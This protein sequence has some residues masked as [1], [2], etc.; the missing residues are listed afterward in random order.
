MAIKG[1]AARDYAYAVNADRRRATELQRAF[2]AAVYATLGPGRPMST[3]NVSSGNINSEMA[4]N[5]A[6]TTAR[7]RAEA[8]KV[9]NV[10]VSSIDRAKV[11]LTRGTEETSSSVDV[12]VA[13]TISAIRSG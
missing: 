6:D 2:G 12:V 13:E 11:V 4:E 10:H 7:T 8:A 9:A 1:D 5:C 3:E